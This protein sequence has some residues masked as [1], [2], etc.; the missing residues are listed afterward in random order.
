MSGPTFDRGRALELAA[1][2]R[3]GCTMKEIAAAIGLSRTRV[4]Q[5]IRK[6]GEPRRVA[7][8]LGNDR[9]KVYRG[10][11][12]AGAV[13]SRREVARE[14]KRKAIIEALK[15]VYVRTGK[16][17]RLKEV[18]AELGL[19]C[20]VPTQCMH[21]MMWL[22]FGNTKTRAAVAMARAYRMA[23]V[24]KPRPGVDYGGLHNLRRTPPLATCRQGH[25]LIGANLRLY[26][27]GALRRCVECKRSYERDYYRRVLKPARR[28]RSVA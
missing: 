13:L 22:A 14:R 18:Y 4:M 1:L 9:E 7:K 16:P 2:Y 11:L 6:V 12:A 24:P 23:G 21:S 15:A 5:L 10:L 27:G 3:G 28:A 17:P 19:K 8:N 26:R 20:R 25:P